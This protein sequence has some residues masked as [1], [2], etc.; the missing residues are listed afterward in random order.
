MHRSIGLSFLVI[1]GLLGATGCA[2]SNDAKQVD[3]SSN[4]AEEVEQNEA[5]QQNSDSSDSDAVDSGSSATV[6]PPGAQPIGADFPFPVPEG[7]PELWPLEDVKIGKT[8][9]KSA[10]FVFPGDASSAAATYQNLLGAAGFE[11]HPSPLAEQ[12]H[13]AGFVVEGNIGGT[14]YAGTLDFDTDAEGVQRVAIHLTP[15]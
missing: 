1:V 15:Q 10:A 2:E 11:V 14:P 13:D 7:W 8:Q 6:M 9:S 12:V 4:S 5:E 3:Q